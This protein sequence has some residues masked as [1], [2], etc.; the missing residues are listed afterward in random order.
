MISFHFLINTIELL[1][2]MYLGYASLYYLVLSIVGLF[3]S[4]P[5]K[6]KPSVL[7]KYAVLIP[8]Y[9]ED[10]V[11]VDVAKSALKQSYPTKDYDVIVIADSFKKDTVNIL[12][13]LDIK[14]IE[15][16]FDLSSK[17]KALNKAMSV[18]EGEYDVALV[19]DADNIMEKDF[20]VKINQ[21]FDQGFKVVQGHRVAKNLNT[22]FAILDAVSEEIC[23]HLFRK[24]HRAIGLSA[25]L[26]GS[27]MAFDYSLFKEMMSNIE[28]IGGFDKE[29][30]LKLLKQ[31]VQI[32]YLEDAL[33]Y[34]EKVQNS[35]VFVK[36][37]R[38]WLSAQFVYFR[39]FFFS[40]WYHLI[41]NGNIDF[42]NKVYHMM[43]PPRILLL[44]FACIF[45]IVYLLLNLFQ[46]SIS[47]VLIIAWYEW[48]LLL[49]VTSIALALSVP[50]KFYNRKTFN[51]IW[52]LPKGF[53]LMFFSFLTIKGANDKFIHTEHGLTNDL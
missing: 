1:I 20:I 21:A 16:S 51:A 49:M 17:A 8:G 45:T 12:K 44:G 48:V 26:I 19:L 34:D 18:L 27:G 43:Q 14:L 10:Q 39:K 52:M 5:K 37:R 9:K 15:V 4:K 11:I 23:N 13:E 35:K 6:S 25:G 40:G 7:R 3:N 32:E 29:L 46:D 33:V 31:Q 50:G 42:F 53:F 38:R 47:N 30:E 28:A 24:A 41:F 36:Q 22:S 2:F